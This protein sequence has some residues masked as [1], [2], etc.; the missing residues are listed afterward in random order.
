MKSVSTST[1]SPGALVGTGTNPAA[2]IVQAGVT[3]SR[4]QY[5]ALGLKSPGKLKFGNDANA[6]LYARPIPLSNIPPHHT[7][8]T[9]AAAAHRSWIASDSVNPPTRPGLMLM[10]RPLRSASIAFAGSGR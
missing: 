3:T 6:T 8:T 1:P 5:R 10:I 9:G 4:A 2:F 7:G